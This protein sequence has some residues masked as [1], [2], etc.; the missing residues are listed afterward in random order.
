MDLG[1]KMTEV[2][3]RLYNY[4]VAVLQEEGLPSTFGR[5]V[6][7]GVYRRF[8]ENALM[9]TLAREKE[10]EMVI[11]DLQSRIPSEEPEGKEG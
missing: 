3:N 9:V 11:A 4:S 1:E 8:V 6:M 10:L 5:L 7:D 2:E